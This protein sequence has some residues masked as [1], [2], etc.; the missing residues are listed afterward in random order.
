M[1]SAES[2]IEFKSEI[3]AKFAA[4][5]KARIPNL[6]ASIK[7]VR[8]HLLQDLEL[9]LVQDEIDRATHRE[10]KDD[11]GRRL[12]ASGFG[13]LIS[14]GQPVDELVKESRQRR[15]I[16]NAALTV[17]LE[18]ERFAN[19]LLAKRRPDTS[20]ITNHFSRWDERNVRIRRTALSS[21]AVAESFL[22]LAAW[23]IVF[24]TP[25]HWTVGIV[26]TIGILVGGWWTY[27]RFDPHDH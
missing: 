22:L 26:V 8:D 4:V 3:C 15:R 18:Y 7:D 16:T 25:V 12:I 2:D 20:V 27:H 10:F 11:L 24:L 13:Q 21:I 5:I 9:E 23:L 6:P 1:A 17:A 14:F 19:E